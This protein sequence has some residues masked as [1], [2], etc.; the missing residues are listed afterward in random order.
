[1]M[2]MRTL[3]RSLLHISGRTMGVLMLTEE[4]IRHT[5]QI[6]KRGGLVVY[7]T[8]TVYG[9]GCDP[10]NVDAVK[11]LIQTKGER[12]KALPL[13]AS[14]T[15]SVTVAHFSQAATRLADRFWPG[16]L[17]LILPKKSILPYAV[18]CNL[19]TV[20]VR[21]PDHE[22]ALQLIRLSGGLLVGT[23]A[24]KTG[25]QPARTASEALVQLGT[26]VDVILDGGV[27]P[28][29]TPS[30]V[31]DLTS[32][33]L[34]ILRKGPISLEEIIQPLSTHLGKGDK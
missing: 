10:F 12:K 6:V 2:L 22:V 27:T 21:V 34:K 28:L 4:N 3:L 33:S 29:G 13:L 23:S 17:T 8:D 18:T 14:D 24:N 11:R 25:E 16:P 20:G 26:E 1:M 19:D 7:P 32:D 9:L 30:T 5:S 15:Q 31:V